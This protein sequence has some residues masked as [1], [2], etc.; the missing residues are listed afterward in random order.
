M[1]MRIGRIDNRITSSSTIE[2][3]SAMKDTRPKKN[4]D[5]QQSMTQ[6]RLPIT[7]FNVKIFEDI[8]LAP[9]IK[10]VTVQ[11]KGIKRASRIVFPPYL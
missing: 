9:A 7:L 10:G 6:S 2:K 4:P 3:C 11:M 5:K 8:R 1:E